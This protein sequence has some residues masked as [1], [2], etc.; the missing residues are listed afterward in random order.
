MRKFHVTVNGNVYE[1]EVEEI[2]GTDPEPTAV[3]QEIKTESKK[4]PSD[5]GTPVSA[6]MPGSIIKVLVSTGSH[7]KTGDLLFILEAMKMENEIFAPQDGVAADI[8]V[9]QGDTVK[10]GDVL[11]M[12]QHEAAIEK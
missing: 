8:K 9:K 2:T 4:V 3:V 10:T 5:S 7:V 1:V 6:P 11:L 12:L